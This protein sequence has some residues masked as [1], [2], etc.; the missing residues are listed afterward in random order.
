MTHDRFGRSNLHTNG[1]LTH[2][3]R[4]TGAPQ[5]DGALNN[6]AR[7][8][9]NHYRQ[10]YAELPEPVVFMPVAA[11]TSGRI[12]EEFLRLLFL[13]AH[14]DASALSGE[15]P[16]ESAQ[17]CFIRTSCLVNLKGSIGL[18]FVKS[19]VMRMYCCLL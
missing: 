4:S 15:L 14:R 1:K 10:K 7:I 2:C 18:V 5:S 17:F 3:F 11:N 6:A 12:N 9:N 16:E 8:K 19:S 13:H